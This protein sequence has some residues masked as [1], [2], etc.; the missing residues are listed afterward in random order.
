MADLH[1]LGVAKATTHTIKVTP[2]NP[3]PGDIFTIAIGKNDCKTID[4]TVVTGAATVADVCAGL[5][6]AWNASTEAE[7]KEITAT[8]FTTYIQLAHDTIGVPF[9]ITTSTTDSGVLDVTVTT[10]QVGS[11]GTNEK[12]EVSIQGTPTGGNFLLTFDGQQTVTP[13]AYNAAAS[14][15]KT[16]LESL[17]NIA[18]DDVAVTLSEQSVWVVEF[19]QAYAATN[20]PRLVGDGSG[21]TGACGVDITETTKGATGTNEKQIVT[22]TTATNSLNYITLTYDGQTTTVVNSSDG[23]TAIEGALAALTNIGAGNV[24]VTQNNTAS[25]THVFVVEFVGSLAGT[26]L[27]LMT[28][29]VAPLGSAQA[30]AVTLDTDGSATGIDEVQR[31]ALTGG[32]L[33]GNF[34]L[35]FSGQTTATPIAFDAAASVVKTELESLSNIDTVTVTGTAPIWS[36]TFEGVNAGTDVA[37]MS[38]SAASLVGAGVSVVAT[39]AAVAAI[40]EKQAV[41][42]DDDATGGTYKLTFNAEETGTIA[43]DATADTVETA[44]EGLTTP[45]PG[46]FVVTGGTGGPYTVEFTGAYASSDVAIMTSDAALLTGGGTQTLVQASV[47]ASTGPEFFDNIANWSTGAIPTDS[48]NVTFDH[49]AVSDLKYALS[50]ATITPAS[51]VITQGFEKKIGLPDINVD[52]FSSPYAEYRDKDLAWC[53]AADALNTTIDIG[54]GVGPGSERIRMDTNAAQVTLVVHNSGRRELNAT[55]PILWKGT[56]ASNSVSV[57]RGDL[58]IAF[59]EGEVANLVTLLSSFTF[60]QDTDVSIVCGAGVVFAAST[61][62]QEGGDVTVASNIQTVDMTGG[63]LNVLAGTA[64]TIT[65]ES[66]SLYYQSNGTLTTLKVGPGA[67]ADFRRDLRG[68]TIT[69]IELYASASW[70]DPTGTVVATNGYDFIRCAPDD[71][72]VFEVAPQRTWTPTAI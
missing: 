23:A 5:V 34:T 31:V 49:R 39:Q 27:N 42:V 33:S 28:A 24:S 62:T 60:S 71:L 63:S 50:Q 68:R 30:V 43:Y 69:N 25:T 8:D 18:L 19:K 59:E 47:I 44:L 38:G 6:A 13:I 66:G 67:T 2:A 70:Y 9:T 37:L 4:F 53:D 20:V 16:E 61:I 22:V 11:A 35:T 48:D 52:N 7:V 64:T 54:E 55:P 45:V 57:Y 3:E 56:H 41:A 26:D 21:I 29:T 51:I 72:E 1:W 40:N 46:D 17:S 12:Q 15:V 14:V 58:G 36:V 65:M 10:V 32:P